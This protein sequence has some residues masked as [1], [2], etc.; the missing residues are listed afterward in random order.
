MLL[1]LYSKY[2]FAIMIL[3]RNNYILTEYLLI[4]ACPNETKYTTYFENR[5][6]IPYLWT[7][8]LYSTP[9]LG[10]LIFFPRESIPREEQN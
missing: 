9:N 8:G 10:L 1:D 7:N 4:K 2:L 6:D 5:K 3:Y